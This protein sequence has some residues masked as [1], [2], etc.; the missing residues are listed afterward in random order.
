MLNIFLHT[1]IFPR[2]QQT[3]MQLYF[4]FQFDG[5]MIYIYLIHMELILVWD[6]D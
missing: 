1:E 2:L 5:L 4:F 3:D 6:L